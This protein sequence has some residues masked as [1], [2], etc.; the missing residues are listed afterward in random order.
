MA[1]LI[2]GMYPQKHAF[3]GAVFGLAGNFTTSSSAVRSN[4][5]YTGLAVAAQAALT[6]NKLS[7]VAIPVD[8]G[9]TY[10]QVSFVAGNTAPTL[11]INYAAVYSGQPTV[12]NATLLAQSANAGSTAPTASAVNTY[13]LT[14]PVTANAVNAPYG[15]WYVGIQETGTVNNCLGAAFSAQVIS[16]N[17]TLFPNAPAFWSGQVAAT[18]G[19]APSTLTGAT[20]SAAGVPIIFLT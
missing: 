18:T 15:Y 3:Q 13:T 12:A 4:I 1:D 7:F 6:T 16:L 19:T 10:S 8:N 5:E 11:T 17:S 14:T 2:S 9:V 20:G